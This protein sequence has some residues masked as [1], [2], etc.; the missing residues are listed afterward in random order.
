MKANIKKTWLVFFFIGCCALLSGALLWRESLAKRERAEIH[1]L[2]TL[3]SV[4]IGN[5]PDQPE[6]LKGWDMITNLPQWSLMQSICEQN[7]LPQPQELYMF[8]EQ[9]MTQRNHPEWKVFL[10]RSKPTGSSSHYGRW[11]LAVSSNNIYR[12]WVAESELS[13]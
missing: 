5:L 10:L 3:Q 2:N 12:V 8:P 7:H 9:T 13:K 11:G 4:L 6:L 1:L